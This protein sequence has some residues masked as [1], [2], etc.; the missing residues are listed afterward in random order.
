[1]THNLEKVDKIIEQLKKITTLNNPSDS[2]WTQLDGTDIKPGQF[3]G[4]YSF[5][6]EL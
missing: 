5:I 4:A 6:L 3:I 2:S 1:V